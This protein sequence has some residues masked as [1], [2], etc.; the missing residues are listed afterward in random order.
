MAYEIK[1]NQGT[2]F[3][4]SEKK[5]SDKHPDYTGNCK[6]NNVV[7]NISAWVNESKSGNKY[8]R[9]KFDE[10]KQQT[11]DGHTFTSTSTETANIPF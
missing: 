2:L 3:N 10:Y 5:K 4:A 8:L 7:M 6:I 11:D 1:D 9:L